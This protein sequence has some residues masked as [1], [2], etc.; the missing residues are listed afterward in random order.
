VNRNRK[1][2]Y[3]NLEPRQ[4]LATLTVTTSVDSTSG[5]VDGEVS[6]REALI[7][8][9]TNA[10]F[11][12]AAAGD[13]VGDRIEFDSALF[14]QTTTLSGTELS[15]TENVTI[16][17]NGAGITINANQQSRVF[18]IATDQSVVLNN[19]TIT[20]GLN[21]TG[22]GIHMAGG[23]TLRLINSNI[24]LN[25]EAN[26]A[27]PES[28]G[29][30]GGV[31]IDGSTLVSSGSTFSDNLAG[32]GGAIYVEGG[33][34]RVFNSVFDGNGASIHGG[35]IGVDS[36]DVFASKATFENNFSRDFLLNDTVISDNV[37]AEFPDFFDETV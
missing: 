19:I 12:D 33:S 24:S 31:F 16:R 26:W 29:I 23:G 17:A 18:A 30:G 10:A 32:A 35:A 22:A 7:A 13:L 6:L 27:P 28:D 1:C 21:Q 2:D 4:L 20:G 25:G 3:A 37:A 11:G 36:S 8:A 9:S 5:T 15:I 14:G 34:I